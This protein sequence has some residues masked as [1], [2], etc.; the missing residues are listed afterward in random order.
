MR[1]VELRAFKPEPIT[2]VMDDLIE[3]PYSEYLEAQTE[4]Y[5]AHRAMR[6]RYLRSEEQ[7]RMNYSQYW[8]WVYDMTLA[9]D[10]KRTRPYPGEDFDEV[11]LK[12]PKTNNP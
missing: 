7:Y 10:R 5:I 1:L 4:S 11:E 12:T 8:K 9:P 3:L 2:W 6:E